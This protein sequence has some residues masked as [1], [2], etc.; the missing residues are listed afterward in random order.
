MSETS[1]A[2]LPSLPLS[3]LYNALVRTAGAG[4]PDRPGGLVWGLWQR[5]WRKSL[6]HFRGPVATT[7]HG[8]RVIVNYGHTYPFYSRWFPGL[9]RPVVEL[10]YQA[11]R[12]LGR[13]ATLVDVGA[14][15][16]DTLLLIEERCPGMLG[17]FACVE[18]DS[19][20]FGYLRGNLGYRP[21]GHFYR[22]LLSD[23]AETVGALV[24]TAAGTASAYGQDRLA[25]QT[26]DSLLSPAPFAPID[27]I[28]ID[29]DGYD[30]KVLLG[31]RGLLREHRPAVLF[32]WHPLYCRQ[33]GADWREPFEALAGCGYTTL[34]WFN[35]YGAW[36]HFSS[37]DD[38]AAAALLA[39]LCLE[40]PAYPDW[41]Y[42]IIALPPGSPIAPRAL[43]ELAYARGA[44]V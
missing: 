8:R 35:K 3:L 38:R 44:G 11:S 17:A 41:H 42:D 31:A 6:L 43:A 2:H 32:E 40:S 13:P 19:E 37:P 33:V 10:V 25:A 15:V 22:V 24:R 30:G 26:L 21:D 20:F 14:N 18:G 29:V 28:K 27:L 23:Q 4:Q 36:S 12:A 5:I 39:E 34:V 1:R 9:N 7:I 16:G